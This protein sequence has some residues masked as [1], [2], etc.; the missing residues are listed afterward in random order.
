MINHSILTRAIKKARKSCC[1][2]KISAMALNR[3]GEVIS[4]TTN[5]HRFDG[6]GRGLH[7]EM[8]LMKRHPKSVK[9]IIICRVGKGGDLRPVHP[10]KMCSE[11]A[12]ELGVKIITLN[13]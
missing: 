2:F 8:I 1:L 9:T 13:G 4:T 12:L 6:K 3:K 7:A 10:C 11:K 5:R